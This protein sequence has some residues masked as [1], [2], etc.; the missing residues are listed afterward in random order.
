M[1]SPPR[2]WVI[3]LSRKAWPSSHSDY[4][5]A[6]VAGLQ[7]IDRLAW[8]MDSELEV[9]DAA[10]PSEAV[11]DAP[12]A[13]GAAADRPER[14]PFV[15]EADLQLDQL[16]PFG[17]RV[18][19]D[20][21]LERDETAIEYTL[22]PDRDRGGR[23][24]QQ[25]RGVFDREDRRC[26]RIDEAEPPR[27]TRLHVVGEATV[28][29]RRHR[30]FE[31]FGPFLWLGVDEYFGARE[32]VPGRVDD[33]AADA[34]P[35]TERNLVARLE[36]GAPLALPSIGGALPDH[37]GLHRGRDPQRQPE[38]HRLAVEAPVRLGQVA[39]Q[40][41][42]ARPQ[43]VVARRKGSIIYPRYEG[44]PFL[45]RRQRLPVARAGAADFDPPTPYTRDSIGRLDGDASRIVGARRF[46][47]KLR[48]FGVEA[49]VNG[50]GG[51]RSLLVAVFV[52]A[53]QS[54]RPVAR[55]GNS[56]A[57][58]RRDRQSGPVAADA[59]VAPFAAEPVMGGGDRSPVGLRWIGPGEVEDVGVAPRFTAADAHRYRTGRRI[60][61]VHRD[62]WRFGAIA[63]R[64]FGRDRQRLRAFGRFGGLDFDRPPTVRA[65]DSLRV[66]ARARVG[67]AHASA[68]ERGCALDADVVVR[69]IFEAPPAA[70]PS[71]ARERAFLNHP[72]RRW[73][74]IRNRRLGSEGA[75]EVLAACRA[76]LARLGA[77]ADDSLDNPTGAT[78][79]VAAQAR[80]ARRL[81]QVAARTV[82]V[83]AHVLDRDRGGVW[84]NGIELERVATIAAARVP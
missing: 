31:L 5:L 56:H 33:S 50:L 80:P 21:A 51:V 69:F 38:S 54:Q 25:G 41:V 3:G 13:I 79:V 49:E 48:R 23:L 27:G 61:D 44:I 58:D 52:L 67:A 28:G 66:V 46:K 71:A 39:R 32:S 64:V 30:V 24:D 9:L 82:T 75:D 77:D 57:A 11:A 43:L 68:E 12:G 76:E 55:R 78:E 42:G 19:Q 29:V 40:V 2:L 83:G 20:A 70:H 37:P 1:G 7:R 22:R 16:S 72:D 62:R 10:G 60:V 65:R 4:P 47:A 63:S 35:A 45:A 15:S 53:P 81:S 26:V 6:A 73:T 74:S 18:P 8:Q 59:L 34:H 84:A 17:E 36:D 14:L